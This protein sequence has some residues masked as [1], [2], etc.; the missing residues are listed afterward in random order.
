MFSWHSLHSLY[1]EASL[2]AIALAI[3]AYTLL[4]G[5][6]KW[7]RTHGVILTT[8][9]AVG[10]LAYYDELEGWPFLDTTYFLTVTITTV[11]YGDLTPATT[12]G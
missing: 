3:F 6:N 10:G 11:G 5:K 1:A 12:E 4:G 8:Y 2:V 7:I 9:Y